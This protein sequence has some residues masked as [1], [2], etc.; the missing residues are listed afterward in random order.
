MYNC[1]LFVCLCVDIKRFFKN[2]PYRKIMV[3]SKFGACFN[4]GRLVING[5][6][7]IFCFLGIMLCCV[8]CN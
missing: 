1:F 3:V 5:F 6:C 4:I 7:Y 8:A 2:V